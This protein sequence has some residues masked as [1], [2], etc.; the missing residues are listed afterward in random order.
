VITAGFILTWLHATTQTGQIRFRHL[1]NKDGLSQNTVNCIYQDRQGFIWIGTHDGLNKYDGNKFTVY[2]HAVGDSFAIAGNRINSICEDKE[3]NIWVAMRNKGVSCLNRSTGKFNSFSHGDKDSLS[4]PTD[5]AGALTCN[6][7]TGDVW[8]GTFNGLCLYDKKKK[9]FRV[10]KNDK[11]VLA[12]ISADWCLDNA[13]VFDNQ[14]RLWIS[15]ARGLNY[16][17]DGGKTFVNYRNN[18]TNSDAF[19]P[20]FS[21]CLYRDDSGNIWYTSWSCKCIMKVDPATLKQTKYE[22]PQDAGTVSSICRSASGELWIGTNDDG[23]L[24]FNLSTGKY[25]SY[26]HDDLDPGSV[27]DYVVWNIFR[28]K[29]G[30]MWL[31]T[32]NGVDY[33]NPLQERFRVIAHNEREYKNLPKEEIVSLISAPDGTIW[34][35]S[36]KGLTSYRPDENL[37][38]YP[39][40]TTDRD[41]TV[42]SMLLQDET[43]WLGTNSGLVF[44]DTKTKKYSTKLP[45][46]F[47]NSL[48]AKFPI[49]TIF[50]DADD[51]IW[52]GLWEHG[53]AQYSEQKRQVAYY[54]VDTSDVRYRIPSNTPQCITQDKEKNIWIGFLSASGVVKIDPHRQVPEHIEY[55]DA[56]RNLVSPV[57]SIYIEKDGYIWLGTEMAGLV[58]WDPRKNSYTHYGGQQ[59]LSN[60]FVYGITPDNT[61]SLW[62]TTMNG[63]SLFNPRLKTF[64][65]FY[66]EDGIPDNDFSNGLGV[67]HS[68]GN[69][70]IAD[71]YAL[72]SVDPLNIPADTIA[73]RVSLTSFKKLG[74]EQLVADW[75]QSLRISYKD[76]YF[77]IEFSAMNYINPGRTRY[78]YMLEGFDEDWM[79]SGDRNYAGYTN[80]PGGDY[81]FK[82]KATNSDGVWSNQPSILKIHITTPFWHT[83]WFYLLCIAAVFSLG[84]VAYRYRMNQV[85]K[86]QAVRNRIAGDLHDDIGSTLSSISMMSRMAKDNLQKDTPAAAGILDKVVDRSQAM[87]D[88]MNDIVWAINPVNDA[89]S[90]M[91]ARMREFASEVLEA[92]GIEYEII[93]S[94]DMQDYKF[95]MSNRRDFFLI[96]KEAIN[97]LAKYSQCTK[98]IIRLSKENGKM[99]LEVTDNGIGFETGSQSQ[100]NGL[101]N[102]RKRAET[103]KGLLKIDST[104]GEGTKI[105]LEV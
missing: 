66:H 86:L 38:N 1:G 63:L 6:P 102:M 8:V 52:L 103:I 27:S 61:G 47:A 75:S 17:A 33:Y 29:Q 82:V 44:F 16:T 3:G 9:G 40:P 49:T 5:L 13:M 65:G 26:I 71:K 77:S 4:L 41:Y 92:K 23:L 36:A 15:T 87:L 76:N 2:R 91:A 58:G 79:Y 84:Y 39:P 11:T 14:G 20:D 67:R 24:I 100:G 80:L 105:I 28:D 59:G 10:F 93:I 54:K 81:I 57:R 50:R 99:L 68:N 69:I 96:F 101:Y 43:I 88:A 62:L 21:S 48:I 42:W 55:L 70:Y 45:A 74:H 35:G 89:L 51:Y 97:N 90:S 53:L 98:A 72:I 56:E 18:P 94:E 73:P 32:F 104:K 60:E 78:A 37:I 12:S 31:A 83:A 22:L 25:S 85:L 19:R 30:T 34:M 64:R 95:S 7:V 46:A